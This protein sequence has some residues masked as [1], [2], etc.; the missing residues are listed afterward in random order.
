MLATGESVRR[1]DE[2]R[3]TRIT[4]VGRAAGEGGQM[5]DPSSNKRTACRT[6][7]TTSVGI[8]P[9]YDVFLRR[10]SIDLT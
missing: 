9:R 8:L 1:C 6:V 2:R 7:F 4:R 3:S 5:D 10:Q